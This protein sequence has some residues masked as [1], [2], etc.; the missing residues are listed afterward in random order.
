MNKKSQLFLLGII[1]SVVVMLLAIFPM[2]SYAFGAFNNPMIVAI[3]HYPWLIVL[4]TLCLGGAVVFS[5][6]LHKSHRKK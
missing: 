4:A 2:L 6:L 3:P 5:V 1:A